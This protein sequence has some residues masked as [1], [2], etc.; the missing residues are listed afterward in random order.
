MGGR[1]AMSPGAI[2]SKGAGRHLHA[3]GTVFRWAGAV[4]RHPPVWRG[5]ARVG[6]VGSPRQSAEDIAG[7]G[8][9]I[10]LNLSRNPSQ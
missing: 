4:R 3:E 7:G 9:E 1:Q 8:W 5:C 2:G 6:T 10:H